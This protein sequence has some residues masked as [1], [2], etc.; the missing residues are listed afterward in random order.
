MPQPS[1]A[2]PN[3]SALQFLNVSSAWQRDGSRLVRFLASTPPAFISTK[4]SE[5][6]ESRPPDP[7]RA[8]TM[9]KSAMAPS[10]TGFL[11]P[12]RLPLET[13]SLMFCGDG[14]PLPSKS[15]SVPIASPAAIN[16]NHLR[17]CASLPA[18]RIVSA[19]RYTVDENGTGASARP[20]S[21]ATTQSSR[22]PAPA[23][24]NS[25]GMA[26]PR[27]PISASPFHKLRSYGSLPSSTVRTAFGGHFS[28]RNFRA[29]SRNCFWSSEKSKFMACY[30]LQFVVPANAGTHNH[31]RLCFIRSGLQPDIDSPRR[32]GPRF[33]GDDVDRSIQNNHLCIRPLGVKPLDQRGAAFEAGAL[34]DVALVG[35]FIA[36]D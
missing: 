7:V 22:W 26:T 2:A 17:F 16:G 1:P 31:W 24:P 29:S 10:G 8:A 35:Q 23:P 6:S 28:A 11:T 21:S 34:V 15:A 13:A 14:L 33:R 30:S 32:M 9:A 5:I 25:S 27:K 3:G 12:L 19:A 4:N 36:V 20:I 18:S